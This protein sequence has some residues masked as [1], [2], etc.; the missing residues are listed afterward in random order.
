LHSMREEDVHHGLTTLCIGGGDAMAM[1]L[2][3]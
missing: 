1:A 3:R 2:E